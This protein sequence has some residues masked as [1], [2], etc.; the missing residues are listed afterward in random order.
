MRG[1]QIV[2]VR[3]HCTALCL[4]GLVISLVEH[5][6]PRERALRSSTAA[7]PVLQHLRWAGRTRQ[8]GLSNGVNAR[9]VR[10]S[11]ERS[12]ASDPVQPR[13]LASGI[14]SWRQPS[15]GLAASPKQSSLRPKYWPLCQTSRPME[16]VL[17]SG[18]PLHWRPPSPKPG[19]RRDYCNHAHNHHFALI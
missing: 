13:G 8:S 1:G 12:A 15:L 4:A 16:R 3:R 10:G 14:E 7:E 5:I 2:S 11:D 18:F 9:S 17:A 19:T 6:D